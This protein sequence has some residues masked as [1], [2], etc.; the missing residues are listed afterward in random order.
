MRP[1]NWPR[2]TTLKIELPSGLRSTAEQL[3]EDN[4][5]FFRDTRLLTT[6]TSIDALAPEAPIFTALDRAGL[7][8]WVHYH[9]IKGVSPASSLVGKFSEA[10]DGVVGLDSS[11]CSFAE[12]EITVQSEHVSIHRT[13]T[14]IL[15]VRRILLLPD[16]QRMDSVR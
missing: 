7:S 4:P 14:T 6:S 8:P 9:N 11:H 16:Q 12:S 3:I 2:P 10:G 13:S 5:G 15:E 1:V